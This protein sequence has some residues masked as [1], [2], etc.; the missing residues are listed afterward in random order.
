[1][2]PTGGIWEQMARSMAHPELD[3]GTDDITPDSGS[4]PVPAEVI[5]A[6]ARAIRATGAVARMVGLLRDPSACTLTVADIMDRC[7][8]LKANLARTLRATA[9][10]TVMGAE[11]WR[12]EGGYRGFTLVRA[13]A[14]RSS[15]AIT[16]PEPWDF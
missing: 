5:S 8:I 1:M 15:P 16:L 6:P 10:Q 13:T 7:G 2:K 12:R 3:N 4:D 14:S 9:V 11:G